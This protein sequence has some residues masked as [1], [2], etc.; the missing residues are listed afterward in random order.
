MSHLTY[1]EAMIIGLIQGVTEL[2][3]VSSLGHS[4][5]IPALVGGSWAQDLSVSRPESPYL[6]LIVGLHVATA[7]AMIIYFRHDWA[8]IVTGFFSSVRDQTIATA[9]QKLA[10]MIV[11]P[12]IP[13]GL[14][15]LALEHTFRVGSASLSRPRCS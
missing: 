6:A 15:G 1:A 2:F 12:T 9:G 14:S 8:R 7:T 13:V 11:L 3:P 10:W 4:V 5:L